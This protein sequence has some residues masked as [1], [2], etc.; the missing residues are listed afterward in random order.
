MESTAQPSAEFEEVTLDSPLATELLGKKVGDTIILAKGHIQD[1]T[2]TIIQIMPKSV[3]RFQDSLQQ[4]QIR[5]GSA[6]AVESVRVD[7]SAK[8]INAS[9]LIPFLDSIEKRA[10][11][12]AQMQDL[13]QR[14]P[15][16]LHLFGTG[17]GMNAYLALVDLAQAESASVK[18]CL[19]TAGERDGA[20]RAL[21]SAKEV[22]VDLTAL[23]TLRLLGLTKILTSKTYRFVVAAA[24]ITTIHELLTE[25]LL[26]SGAGGSLHYVDGKHVMYQVTAEDKEM[27]RRSDEE[28]IQFVEKTLTVQNG[29]A[30]PS[31]QKSGTLL[32]RFLVRMAQNR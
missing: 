9:G 19:G 20:L 13:Y 22:V 32:K 26:Q 8:D 21:Q 5:F 29:T 15:V 24:T 12:A 1:R 10:A 14:S 3:R 28:F 7:V 23:C 27:R 30:L 18:C 6:S 11:I 16:P 4:M 31:H 17:F 2:A 25:S